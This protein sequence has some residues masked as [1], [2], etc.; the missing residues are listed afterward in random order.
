MTEILAPA[1][2]K[3]HLLTAVNHGADAV[4]MGLKR[5]SARA[6]AE[7]FSPEEFEYCLNYAHCF[8][9]KVYAAMNTL[10]KDD[11]LNDFFKD[12]TS[13]YRMGV[14]AFII[15]D[16]FL[17]ARLKEALG[18]IRLHLSTQGGAC[19]KYGARTA[20]EYGFARVV[21]SRESALE[22]LK[23][24]AKIVEVETFVQGALC[25]SFSGQCYFSAFAGGNSANRGRCKQPCRKLYSLNGRT[26]CYALSLKDL[27]TDPATFVSLA[28]AGVS[29]FKI[30]GRM[31]RPEYVGAAVDYV[32][33]ALEGGDTAVCRSALMR[34][35]NRGG[36]TAGV[37]REKGVL[38]TSHP[39]HI[40]EKVGTVKS[41]NGNRICVYSSLKTEKGDGFKI[42]RN[43]AE[44]GGA[45]IWE[46]HNGDG[47]F[48]AEGRGGIRA[49]DDVHITTDTRLNESLLAL[50]AQKKLHVSVIALNGQPLTAS[51]DCGKVVTVSGE[52][53]TKALSSPI[54]ESDIKDCFTKT[55]RYP[56]DVNV[57]V[58]TDGVF[59]AKSVLNGLRRRLYAECFSSFTLKRNIVEG[60]AERFFESAAA[61]KRERHKKKTACISAAPV[62]GADIAV[63]SP[64]DYGDSS[65]YDAFL[66]GSD[67]EK[68]LAMPV[69]CTAAEIEAIKKYAVRFDGLYCDNIGGIRIAREW[70]K[71]L[72]M[73]TGFNLF[74]SLSARDAEQECA[75]FAYS[76]ELSAEEADRIGGGFYAE[77]GFVKTMDL[78]YCPYGGDC[79]AC[80][81]PDVG[82]LTD[83]GGRT[84]PL[85][86][87]KVSACRFEVYNYAVLKAVSRSDRLVNRVPYGSD[88]LK[89]YNFDTLKKGFPVTE[90]RSRKG[91]V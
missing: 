52:V 76:K 12:V 77:S 22:D 9:V 64:A 69:Y 28:E 6:G 17:G 85:R 44:T 70:G 46:P 3:E 73:G 81:A 49:G 61:V 68:F 89:T 71:R 72:F 79:S 36:Y 25:T 91:V 51:A 16:V 2:G 67:G 82:A 50:R 27:S 31:R 8:G 11:E 56:F 21:A 75:Y 86:R 35:Y 48:V 58:R 54:G 47:T 90:G 38:F 63:Y 13:L 88:G 24:M 60:A 20:K 40:G 32:R 33:A 30:E 84:F 42:L 15:Q 18:D 80:K 43:G 5:F 62:N 14:D 7:N 55:D 53:L 39:G 26:M 45:V 83:E 34:T 19:N 74:N 78:V 29:A 1:G 59:A 37:A 66:S 65:G 4:Y 87:I 23:E 41:V 57:S 10:V